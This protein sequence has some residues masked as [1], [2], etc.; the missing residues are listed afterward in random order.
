[1]GSKKAKLESYLRRDYELLKDEM[2][3]YRL[4]PSEIVQMRLELTG[5]SEKYNIRPIQWALVAS[6]ISSIIDIEILLDEMERNV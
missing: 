4:T 1:M 3:L 2:E 5:I 6:T